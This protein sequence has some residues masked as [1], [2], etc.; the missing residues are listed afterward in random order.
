MASGDG[1]RGVPLDRVTR[2]HERGAF[3]AEDG[4]VASFSTPVASA[5][6][7]GVSAVSLHVV[8]TLGVPTRRVR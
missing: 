4:S 7:S 3:S 5:S 2:R 1:R 6:I 8:R